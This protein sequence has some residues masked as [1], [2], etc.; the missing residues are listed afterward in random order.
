MPAASV[1]G[2]TGFQDVGGYIQLTPSNSRLNGNVKL[3]VPYYLVAH[4]RSNLAVTLSGTAMT[5]TNTGGAISTTPGFYTWGLSQPAP[6]GIAQ[7]DVRAVGVRLSGTNLVFGLNTHNRTSTT[8]ARQQ[9]N[10]CIDTSGGPGFTPNL[11]LL[12]INGSLLSSSL[13]ASQYATALFPTDA[14]CNINGSG[15]ILFIMTQPTDNSTLQLAVPRGGS[16]SAGLGL[17]SA[18]PRF[19]YQV[20]YFGTD[21]FGAQMPGTGSFNAFTP[22]V[23]FGAAPTVPP[24]GS[25]AASYSVNSE[26]SNTPALGVMITAPDNVSGAPQASLLPF[27]S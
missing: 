18:N 15:S 3:S 19:K 1:G 12:G 22:A 9:I 2:G 24:N 16:G 11:M 26:F 21:G 17:T 8:L 6:Q 14:S 23:T 4:S 10:I 5:F 7:V 27:G 20:R 13:A 25:G